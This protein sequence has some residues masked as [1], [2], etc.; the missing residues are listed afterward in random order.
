T[1]IRIPDAETLIEGATTTEIRDRADELL[2]AY[3]A[4]IQPIDDQRSTAIYRR[5]TALT[6]IR[7]LLDH[8][9]PTFLEQS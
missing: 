4:R 5:N 1:V 9:L 7:H 8:E 2:D 6:L 3:G